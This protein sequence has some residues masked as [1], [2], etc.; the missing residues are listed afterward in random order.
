MSIAFGIDIGGSG[1]K[2]APVDLTTGELIGSRKRIPTPE[3]STPDAVA[4]ICAEVLA[5]FDV[6]GDTP[7]GVSLP[8]PVRHGEVLFMANLHKDWKGTNSDD[9]MTRA[10]GRPVRT[11]NDADAAGYAE[12]AY[13]AAKDKMGTVIV[14]TLGTGI[15]S[16]VIVDGVL[17]PNTELGHLEI[18]G[19][20]AESRAASSA[21]DREDL[22]FKQWAKRLTTYYAHLEML[23]SPDLFVV[24]GGVSK[25]HAEF[26]HLVKVKTPMVPAALR[27]T[28]GI[29]GAA[30]LA[31][32]PLTVVTP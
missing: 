1:I 20:N 18:D 9:L 29:V 23:F 2:G 22:S 8:G 11:V 19:H 12:V 21:R 14:T 5:S 7:V 25:E 31:A 27:N 3:K 6:D 15:G 32:P 28:A 4:E 24:G 17:V 10:L 16:A 26:L 13:G 30:R